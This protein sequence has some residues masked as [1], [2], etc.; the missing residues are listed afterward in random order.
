LWSN[1][2]KYKSSYLEILASWSDQPSA[3]KDH[4]NG[5]R[6]NCIGSDA[7]YNM[8]SGDSGV[9]MNWSESKSRIER[10][11]NEVPEN[12]SRDLRKVKYPKG[13]QYSSCFNPSNGK[14]K[15]NGIGH[16]K[17]FKLNNHR[18]D[19]SIPKYQNIKDTKKIQGE[20]NKVEANQGC[21][22]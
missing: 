8:V 13:T 7:N 16:D 10:Q 11:E 21:S 15:T 14:T 20:T 12:R 6:S 22:N 1:N 9:R 17:S 4:S 19:R 18:D 2:N 3:A 5:K